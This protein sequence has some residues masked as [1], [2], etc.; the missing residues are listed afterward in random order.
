M[1]TIAHSERTGEMSKKVQ[2]EGGA[3]H[4][5]HVANAAELLKKATT[6]YDAI[7]ELLELEQL[8]Y[9][10]LDALCGA[11]FD[12]LLDLFQIK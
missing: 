10:S 6:H 2:R 11:S 1:S 8:D 5:A 4:A 12:L 3:A 7:V 9:Y